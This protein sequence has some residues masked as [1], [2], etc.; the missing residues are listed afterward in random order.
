MVDGNRNLLRQHDDGQQIHYQQYCMIGKRIGF[1]VGYRLDAAGDGLARR[2]PDEIVA[3]PPV[4]DDEKETIDG[5]RHHHQED[6]LKGRERGPWR[7]FGEVREHQAE[8]GQR[9]NQR[10]KRICSPEVVF[11]LAVAKAAQQ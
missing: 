9:H 3:M 4:L 7:G 2:R 8:H 5:D 10:Q 11:L 1:A 6:G